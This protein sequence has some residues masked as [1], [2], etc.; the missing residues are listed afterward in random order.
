M[1]VSNG[2]EYDHVT[3]ISALSVFKRKVITPIGSTHRMALDGASTYVNHSSGGL[4]AAVSDVRLG[5]PY[6]DI[7]VGTCAVPASNSVLAG[8]PV[9]HTVGT[10]VLTGEQLL[11]AGD[12]VAEFRS[13]FGTEINRLMV[14]ATVETV[15][16]QIAAMTVP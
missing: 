15:G 6:G 1:L 2:S 3:G 9:D 14:S 7:L 13:S 5:V 10:A 11:T 16:A 4:H 8:T 12:I